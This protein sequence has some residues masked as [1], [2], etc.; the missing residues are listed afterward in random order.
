MQ[1]WLDRFLQV[2]ALWVWSGMGMGVERVASG[3]W[4]VIAQ[5]EKKNHDA[6][7]PRATRMLPDVAETGV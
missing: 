6:P 5:L 4:C 3:T 7:S 2:A 1:F